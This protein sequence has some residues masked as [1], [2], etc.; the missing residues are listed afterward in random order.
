M[1]TRAT[2]TSRPV[3]TSAA[4][5]GAGAASFYLTRPKPIQ[6]ESAMNPGAG[7]Q[8]APDTMTNTTK[9]GIAAPKKTF[10]FPVWSHG[11]KVSRVEQINHDTKKITFELPEQDSISGIP[12][13]A[14]VLTQHTPSG[15]WFPVFRPYTPISS[16]DTPGS[17]TLLVKKY[18]QGRA[19]AHLHS[20]IP[21]STLTFRG[22][23]P[24]YAYTPSPTTTRSILLIAGGA[25]ITPLYS[26]TKS[27]LS[28]PTDKTRIEL[29]WGVNGPQDMVLRSELSA[30]ESQHPERLSV[31]YAISGP[32][33]D[34]S[35][36]DPQKFP[37]GRITKTILEQV[38]RKFES[39][40][41]SSSSS[42]AAAAK[43]KVS[44]QSKSDPT[45]W[46]DAKGTKVFLCGPPAMEESIASKKTGG[47]L[48][49]LGIG[50][51]EVYRF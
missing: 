50:K 37:E 12:P 28:D 42:A 45:V 48:G 34:L 32:S 49:E 11:L 47:I 5:L 36:S 20:L 46:G 10:T 19:S 17:L 7:T 15:A 44:S 21:G 14:A 1:F 6:F 26:L 2:L 40:P 13:S 35:R 25:G 33:S 51:K 22:P 4:I 38:I 39:Q 24:G 9:A 41:T 23:I 16:P 29:I 18:P 3:I 30:L 43:A 31:T 27:I 8:L